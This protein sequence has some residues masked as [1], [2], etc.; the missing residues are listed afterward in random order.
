MGVGVEPSERQ[1]RGGQDGRFA[2][3]KHGSGIT[4]FE[5]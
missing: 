5:M 2:E 4:I 3:R 1:S